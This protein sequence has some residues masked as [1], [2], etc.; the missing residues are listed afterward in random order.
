MKQTSIWLLR[1][2]HVVLCHII[3]QKAMCCKIKIEAL[4]IVLF[5]FSIAA[6]N[7]VP[8][9]RT[10]L[11]ARLSARAGI[12][13]A[14]G[15]CKLLS[16]CPQY[17]WLLRNKYDIPGIQFDQI[18]QHLWQQRC[19]FEGN[20][21]MVRCPNMAVAPG[22]KDEAISLLFR[23]GGFSDAPLRAAL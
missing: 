12:E 16:K 8:D 23:R 15:H 9:A 19:G 4:S 22:D 1:L 5:V 21:P 2:L 17:L 20:N 3:G 18:Y 13:E 10:L 14:A 7:D 11:L 6:G